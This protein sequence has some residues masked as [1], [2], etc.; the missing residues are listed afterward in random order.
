MIDLKVSKEIYV[1]Y[2]F[3]SRIIKYQWFTDQYKNAYLK[4]IF[5]YV[6]PK[7]NQKM[8]FI[9]AVKQKILFLSIKRKLM[10]NKTFLKECKCVHCQQKLDQINMSRLYWNKI[11]FKKNKA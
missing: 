4:P 3:F 8:I 9:F 10:Q 11:N 2:T 7:V 5:L 1:I 6:I